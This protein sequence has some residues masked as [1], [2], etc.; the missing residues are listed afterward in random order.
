MTAEYLLPFQNRLVEQALLALDEVD[1]GKN[2]RGILLVGAS[3]A[4][5]THSL[6]VLSER[7][8]IRYPADAAKPFQPTS[9]V[10][11]VSADAKADAA[12]TASELLGKLG[13]TTRVRQSMSQL[14]SDLL[15]ALVA[16]QVRLLLFEEFHNTMLAGSPQLRG[17]TSRLLKNIWNMSPPQ[18]SASWAK[19]QPGRGDK[20]LVILV[21]G[22]EDLLQVFEKDKELGSR[23]STVIRAAPLDFAPPGSFR[24][25]RAVVQRMAESE[26]LADCIDVNDDNLAARMLLASNGHL[27]LIATVF[28]RAATLRRRDGSTKTPFPDLLVK[29]FEQVGGANAQKAFLCDGQDLARQVARRMQLVTSKTGGKS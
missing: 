7:I 8:A 11:R 15:A 10:C 6:D 13:K 17:Q 1:A 12:S 26:G 23:F 3:G 2:S 9:P 14:E 25:F 27:R 16:R 29:A 21:S 4:G 5:K 20:R 18:S 28:E 22:T 24:D 19:P